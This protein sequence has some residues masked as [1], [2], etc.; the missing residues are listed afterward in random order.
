MNNMDNFPEAL[1]AARKHK[2]LTQ[3]ALA[4]TTTIPRR[5]IED[6]ET[7]KRTPPGY[8]QRLLLEYIANIKEKE[9]P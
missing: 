3:A 6:W 1:R 9:T 7:G 8:V 5:T 2:G 4:E